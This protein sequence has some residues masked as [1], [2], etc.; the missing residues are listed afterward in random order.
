MSYGLGELPKAGNM[1]G[2]EFELFCYINMDWSGHEGEEALCPKSGSTE[3]LTRLQLFLLKEK[4]KENCLLPPFFFP[5]FICLAV[6][7]ARLYQHHWALTL[8]GIR[9]FRNTNTATN[10]QPEYT[11]LGQEQ[12]WRSPPSVREGCRKE[13][14]RAHKSLQ[15]TKANAILY[16]ACL[17]FWG[18]KKK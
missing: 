5:P 7:I 17:L 1:G 11:R 16:C 4:N 12:R 9:N 18:G 14:E 2:K 13:G 8:F 6:L 15:R 3:Q 10:W